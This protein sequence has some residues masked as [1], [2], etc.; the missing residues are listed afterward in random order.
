MSARSEP[1]EWPD[2]AN[3]LC[4]ARLAYRLLSSIRGDQV[5]RPRLERAVGHQVTD[6]RII[7]VFEGNGDGRGS[8]VYFLVTEAWLKYHDPYCRD[9]QHVHD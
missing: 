4:G 9:P 5:S 2:E 6:L 1:A 3:P 7:R 8:G